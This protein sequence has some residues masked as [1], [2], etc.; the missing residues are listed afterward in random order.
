MPFDAR[1]LVGLLAILVLAV[2]VIWGVRRAGKRLRAELGRTGEAET[3]ASKAELRAIV[4]Q[5]LATP[6]DLARM[7]PSERAMLAAAAL[8]MRDQ[9]QRR[10]RDT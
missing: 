4:E 2:G 3:P 8:R 10:T 9:S 6:A 1:G 5:G 7:R